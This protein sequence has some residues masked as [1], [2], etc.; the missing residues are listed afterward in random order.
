PDPA[1]SLHPVAARLGELLGREVH[2]SPQ[3][4]GPDAEAAV[5]KLRDGELLLLENVRFEPGETKND[6][7]LSRRLADLAE[8]YVNDAFGTAHRAHATTAGV[9]PLVKRRAAGEL[10]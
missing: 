6:P 5:A 7:E 2:F 4:V 3:V 10:L 9:V 1:F 8:V